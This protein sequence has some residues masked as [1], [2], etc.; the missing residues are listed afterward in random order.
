MREG[1]GAIFTVVLPRAEPLQC[2]LLVDDDPVDLSLSVR[3]LR[4]TG[5]EFL[6]A[7]SAADARVM[8]RQ[9]KIHAGLTDYQKRG[10]NGL[11]LLEQLRDAHPDIRCMLSLAIEPAGL[12]RLG[13]REL[14]TH[15]LAS[16]WP[17]TR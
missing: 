12:P 13:G 16:L 17:P 9:E 6:S 15:L 7:R 2:L 1:E 5:L 3:A 11:W 10:E 4:A 14:W 8:G